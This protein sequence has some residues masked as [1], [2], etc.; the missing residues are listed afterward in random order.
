MNNVITQNDLDYSDDGMYRLG[1][2]AGVF[3]IINLTDKIVLNPELLFSNKG[4]K[5]EGINGGDLSGGGNVHLNYINLP[6]L[7]GY[8]IN[9]RITVLAGTELGYLVSARSKFT[10]GATRDVSGIWSNNF[11]IG[12]V[13]GAKYSIV[14]KVSVGLRYTHGF[15][16]VI[17][18]VPLTDVQGNPVENNARYQNRTLQLSAEYALF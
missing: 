5:F 11:D 7:A 12:T 2:H 1:Y 15:L 17:E 14:E 13:V 18:R 4:Y 10:V 9:D 16:S 8:Q 3:S 6:V